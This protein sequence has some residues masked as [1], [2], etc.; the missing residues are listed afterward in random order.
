MVNKD[1]GKIKKYVTEHYGN[2]APSLLR[3]MSLIK[4]LANSMGCH[5]CLKIDWHHEGYFFIKLVKD[6][7]L[8][9]VSL[10]NVVIWQSSESKSLGKVLDEFLNSFRCKNAHFTDLEF[11]D[12]NGFCDIKLDVPYYETDDDLQLQCVLAG[13]WVDIEAA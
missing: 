6:F 13:T 10:K 7:D 11:D 3:K 12:D 4:G 8:G 1:L 9:N 5:A 2:E